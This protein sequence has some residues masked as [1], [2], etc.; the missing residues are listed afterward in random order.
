[1]SLREEIKVDLPRY[2]SKHHGEAP[3][4]S[5]S[6]VDG[7]INKVLDAAIEAVSKDAERRSPYITYSPISAIKAIQKLK[8]E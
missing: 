4:L 8:G 7:I 2:K 6:H 5:D 1:M 3:V